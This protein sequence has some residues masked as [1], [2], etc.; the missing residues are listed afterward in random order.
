MP[1]RIDPDVAFIKVKGSSWS[2]EDSLFDFLFIVL[3]ICTLNA[4]TVEKLE[5]GRWSQSCCWMYT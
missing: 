1:S 2:K 5:V 3:N 4:A